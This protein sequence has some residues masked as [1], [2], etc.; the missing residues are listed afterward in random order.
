ME[1]GYRVAD[2]GVLLQTEHTTI[3]DTRQM[4]WQPHFGI[5]GAFGKVLS[6]DE[7]G[8]PM[9][10]LTFLPEDFDASVLPARQSA[11]TADQRTLV[12]DGALAAIEYGPDGPVA[13]TATAGYWLHHPPGAE[14]GTPDGWQPPAGSL[15]ITYR[16]APGT[17]PGE[18]GFA[19]EITIG[20]GENVSSPAPHSAGVIYSDPAT[21]A[22][23]V[24]SRAMPWA[25]HFGMHL[26]KTKTLTADADGAPLA[27][28]TKTPGFAPGQVAPKGSAE[29]HFHREL[30]EQIFVTGGELTMREYAE[31]DDRAGQLIVLRSGYFVDR[32]PGSIHQLEQRSATGFA[33]LEVRDKP[34]NY[35][36]DEG[37]DE[38]NYIEKMS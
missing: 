9:V 16:S 12:L 5:R 14:F 8:A 7:H 11:R 17:L 36:F 35:P 34:G 3:L 38:L 27:Y 30:T 28:L 20:S 2:D 10:F 33:S 22:R 15:L 26:G 18:A 19:D 13:I 29:R 24:D 6:A 23:V 25:A 4:P 37:F 21:R 32:A 1:V 31:V